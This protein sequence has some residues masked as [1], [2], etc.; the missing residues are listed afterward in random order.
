[1]QDRV[2]ELMGKT[3]PTVSSHAPKIAYA[4]KY[5]GGIAGAYK[6]KASDGLNMRTGPGT[7]YEI[8]QTIQKGTVVRNYG[9]YSARNGV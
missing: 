6:V 4:E 7:N 9:Y 3:K 2:N 1:M 8:V 5:D